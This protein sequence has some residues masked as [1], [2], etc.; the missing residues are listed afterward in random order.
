M[1]RIAA[2]LLCLCLAMPAAAEEPRGDMGEGLGLMEQGARLL[3]RGLM[4]EIEPALREFE[5]V[6]DDLSAY[7]AP[8][9]LPNGDII[10]RRK[11]PRTPDP[12]AP[13]ELEL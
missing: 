5:G 13:E 12:D 11:V 6:I 7:H 10:L 2:P 3:L 4:A 9:I 1:N 8:E